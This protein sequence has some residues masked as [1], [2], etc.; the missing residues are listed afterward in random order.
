MD[1]K[2]LQQSAEQDLCIHL[3][4]SPLLMH[5][6]HDW[7]LAYISTCIHLFKSPLLMHSNHDWDLMAAKFKDPDKFAEWVQDIDEDQQE[8]F[9]SLG[10]DEEFVPAYEV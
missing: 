1:W 8:A 5:S 4:R 7:D 3:F 10:E 2:A 9:S 6:N